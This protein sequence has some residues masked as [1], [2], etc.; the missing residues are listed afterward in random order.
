MN[1]NRN[2]TQ[3]L[4]SQNINKLID[5]NSGFTTILNKFNT[6]L[7]TINKYSSDIIEK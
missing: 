2:L 3:K 4:N 6:E 5:H 1:E 7:I